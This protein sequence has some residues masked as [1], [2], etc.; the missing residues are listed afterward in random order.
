MLRACIDLLGQFKI[1]SSLFTPLQLQCQHTELHSRLSEELLQNLSA[2]RCR[3]A[4][5]QLNK[6]AI[7]VNLPP[8]EPLV[9]Y[10][11]QLQVATK[12]S[13]ARLQEMYK[14]LDEEPRQQ[15][16]IMKEQLANL[17]KD[18]G[19]VATMAIIQVNLRR[20]C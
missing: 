13:A 15:V 4:M 9:N 2:E 10:Q 1:I 6:H 11:A 3:M 18:N 7:R 17:A 12:H 20:A 16:P 8:S 5:S 14:K 19:K